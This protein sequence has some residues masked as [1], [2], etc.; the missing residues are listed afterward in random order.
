MEEAPRA[1]KVVGMEGE[2]A[3]EDGEDGIDVCDGGSPSLSMKVVLAM[4]TIAIE[5]NMA[6]ETVG[7]PAKANTDMTGAHFPPP[8]P[9]AVAPSEAEETDVDNTSPELVIMAPHSNVCDDIPNTNESLDGVIP[10]DATNEASAENPGSGKGIQI[11]WTIYSGDTETL[12]VP[13]IPLAS[14]WISQ[15]RML[16][17]TFTKGRTPKPLVLPL[18][19]SKQQPSPLDRSSPTHL[20]DEEMASAMICQVVRVAV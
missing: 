19:T 13:M 16:V 5:A 12:P 11:G 3:D 9:V 14:S 10:T 2:A 8:V 7:A 6:M 20:P 15:N 17:S 4:E 18:C 1:M